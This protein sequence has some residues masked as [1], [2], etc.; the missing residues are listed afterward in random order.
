MAALETA[1]IQLD[2]AQSGRD[3]V[4]ALT[5]TVLAFE[6]G[7][8]AIREGLRG[9]V[10]AE[11]QLSAALA[12]KEAEASRLIGALQIIGQRPAPQL[13]LHPQ[14]PTGAAR[15]AMLLADVTPTL[16]AEVSALRAELEA[17]TTLRKLQQ[18][19]AERLRQGLVGVQ[20]ARAALAQAIADRTP[21][22]KRFNT[23]PIKTAVLIA[24]SE[25]LGAFASG[26]TEI[27]VDEVPAPLPSAARL[28]GTFE[29]PV[30]GTVL[31]HYNEPD[32]A[33][34][35]RPGIVLA[36]RP[37]ALVTAPA[38]GTIRFQGDLL[39]YGNVM[40]L[41]PARDVL[42]VLAGLSEVYVT[43]GD[44]INAGAP[45]GLMGG[46]DGAGSTDRTQ[47]L[48]I[49]VRHEE[50]TADPEAWFALERK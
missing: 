15:S 10:Q 31:R 43:T 3:R 39:D 16:Q 9:A 27:A 4:A 2:Q 49:E 25:T 42:L 1:A 21:L 11:A 40:I 29:Q 7:L 6:D 46:A 36:T 33:G 14:G 30:R 37:S 20:D 32:A 13:L 38:T 41:E 28:R 44:V 18:D 22:P 47:T 23:D 19:A 17:V 12:A 35:A 5:E 24:A 45:V 48:Y 26:L 50:K 8:A 34:V